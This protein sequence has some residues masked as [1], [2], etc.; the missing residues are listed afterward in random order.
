MYTKF[1]DFLGNAEGVI[2]EVYY[3]SITPING[4]DFDEIDETNYI[5]HSGY[6]DVGGEFIVG[7]KTTNIDIDNKPLVGDFGSQFTKEFIM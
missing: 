5:I 1:S 3:F 6:V 4:L 7:D 2:S